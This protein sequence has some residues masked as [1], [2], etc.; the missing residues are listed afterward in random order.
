MYKE[1]NRIISPVVRSVGQECG[2][3]KHNL[4]ALKLAVDA[5]KTRAVVCKENKY[6][7][8]CFDPHHM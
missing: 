6:S 2:H 7:S 3:V 5:V 8:A 1:L 4:I